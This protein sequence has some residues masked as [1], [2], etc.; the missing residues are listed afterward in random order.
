MKL[1][2]CSRYEALTLSLA[3]QKL[4]SMVGGVST[5]RSRPTMLNIITS[6]RARHSTSPRIASRCCHTVAMRTFRSLFAWS[7]FMQCLCQETSSAY[8]LTHHASDVRR[9]GRLHARQ[10]V[11]QVPVRPMPGER[12]MLVC[13]LLRKPAAHHDA[14]HGPRHDAFGAGIGEKAEGETDRKRRG[15]I[16]VP[17]A[18]LPLIVEPARNERVRLH[19]FFLGLSW[20]LAWQPLA[21]SWPPW[22]P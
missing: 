5:M 22:R 13:L 11:G 8:G 17:Q 14:E 1:P 2:I 7:G 10:R 12:R 21:R 16:A 19:S 15:H 6:A 3:T 18:D 9:R 20:V 4:F